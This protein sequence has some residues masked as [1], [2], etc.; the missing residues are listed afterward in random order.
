MLEFIKELVS[1]HRPQVAIPSLD[2]PW[3]PNDRLEQQP[4]VA[5]GLEQP[6]AMTADDAGNLFV[7]SGNA[8]LC[9]GGKDWSDRTVAA[10]FAA[11]VHG[12]T[13]SRDL[14]LT[15]CLSG[16][17]VAWLGGSRS[18]PKAIEAGSG[19]R[20]LCPT[21]SLYVGNDTLVVADGSAGCANEDYA[22][23]YLR[24]GASGRLIEI[25]VASGVTRNLIDHLR[26]PTCLALTPAGDAVLFAES[27]RH[28]MVRLPLGTGA[29]AAHDFGRPLPGFPWSLLTT[30]HDYWMT[31]FAM[32]THLMEFVLGETQFRDRMIS[33]VSRPYW[34]APVFRSSGHAYEPV[35]GGQLKQHGIT[36][37]WAPPRS[38]GLALR[39][40]TEGEPQET[41]HSRHGGKFHGLAGLCSAR[42]KILALS[43]A[44]GAIIEVGNHE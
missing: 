4:V 27:W 14:G 19:Q 22:L 15:A 37:P 41:L 11:P 2:G 9:L 29:G 33:T 1:P 35:Q 25:N 5:A 20:I 44:A 31:L 32:R 10:E 36:K 43:R 8:V 34:I 6:T 39:M 21:A 18:G 16:K 7:A 28:Q 17:G 40:D 42:G 30:G 13:W 24:H 26:F 23:D 38:Y 12:L 3:S